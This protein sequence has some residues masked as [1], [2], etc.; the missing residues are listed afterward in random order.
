MLLALGALS[1]TCW[2]PL[3]WLILRDIRHELQRQTRLLET[4]GWLD[5]SGLY[6]LQEE[7]EGE[8]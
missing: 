1:L 7:D 2:L 5:R 4:L 8:E 3:I 6:P